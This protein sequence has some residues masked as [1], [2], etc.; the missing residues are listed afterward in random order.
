MRASRLIVAAFLIPVAGVFSYTLAAAWNGDESMIDSNGSAIGLLVLVASIFGIARIASDSKISERAGTA[1]AL[2][3]AYFLLTWVRYGDPSLSA[4]DQPHLVWFGLSVV[5][6]MPSVV[7]IPASKWAW[8]V[9]RSRVS[10][11]VPA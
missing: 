8:S 4:D 6:F 2:A 11:P 1:L 7:L 9:Y 3:S 10:A 5:A